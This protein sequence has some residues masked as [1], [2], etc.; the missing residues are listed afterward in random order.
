MTADYKA[1]KEYFDSVLGEKSDIFSQMIPLLL[2]EYE[3][4]YP[5]YE[6]GLLSDFLIKRTG[7]NISEDIIKGWI[8]SFGKCPSVIEDGVIDTLEYLKR[9]DSSLIVLTNW[10]L[11]SQNE[12]LKSSGLREY[13]DGIIAGDIVLKPRKEAYML[14]REHYKNKECLYIGDNLEKDYVGPRSCGIDSILYD[15]DDKHNNN[16]VK[17][18][19]MKEIRNLY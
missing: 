4:N 16:I 18:K 6:I 12:R 14:A 7:Y 9:N 1:E 13:F 11:D 8:D 15:K 17:V 3:A 5:R 19:R 10:F 2:D